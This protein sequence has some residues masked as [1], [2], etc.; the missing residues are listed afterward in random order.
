MQKCKLLQRERSMFE[1]LTFL[2]SLS[3]QKISIITVINV[4][5]PNKEQDVS[6]SKI[7]IIQILKGES[8]L[9]IFK[10]IY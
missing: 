1:A 8:Y 3:L 2:S 7:L 9:F 5:T 10:W 6:K 4:F